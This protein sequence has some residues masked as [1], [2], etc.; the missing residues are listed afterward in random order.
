MERYSDAETLRLEVLKKCDLY[1]SRWM[2][3]TGDP[4]NFLQPLFHP[5]NVS[6]GTRYNNPAVNEKMALAQGMVHPGK[7]A[8]LY[9]EIQQLIVDDAPWIFLIH[10]QW[11][12][13]ARKGLLGLNMSCLGLIKLEDILIDKQTNQ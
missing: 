6:N 2:A 11:A 1:I 10:P 3:D 12:V 5:E 4:D 8:Q 13:A 9:H 7:R